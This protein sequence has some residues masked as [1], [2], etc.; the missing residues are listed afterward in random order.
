MLL[1]ELAA[2]SVRGFSPAARVALKPGYLI[3]NPVG[4]ARRARVLLPNASDDLRP[5]GPL[6][7][8]VCPPAAAGC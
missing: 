2:Q 8:A 7:A 3:L 6:R 1:L 4:V 5:E